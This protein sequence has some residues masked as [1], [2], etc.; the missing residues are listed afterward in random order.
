MLVLIL[1]TCNLL[2]P[3]AIF[4]N[5]WFGWVGAIVPIESTNTGRTRL[6]TEG[7]LTNKGFYIRISTLL[8]F[9]PTSVNLFYFQ[10]IHAY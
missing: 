6:K 9:Q 2:I 3:Q 8:G 4:V 5:V 1:L 10:I 7:S